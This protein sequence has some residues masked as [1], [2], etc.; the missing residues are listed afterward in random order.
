MHYEAK[1]EKRPQGRKAYEKM[2]RAPKGGKGWGAKRSR[3]SGLR[4]KAD[5]RDFS[6]G[7]LPRVRFTWST[8]QWASLWPS[9]VIKTGVSLA[10][11]SAL[12]CHPSQPPGRHPLATSYP[13][14]P[15]ARPFVCS[16]RGSSRFVPVTASFTRSLSSSFSFALS[17]AD[18]PCRA[19][20]APTTHFFGLD[21]LFFWFTS[22]CFHASFYR[23]ILFLLT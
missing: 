22:N 5:F 12:F 21:F 11:Q 10:T 13:L 2:E 14:F 15:S 18:G 16:V 9:S 7:L 8:M 17:A 4:A 1:K 6:P 20:L 3:V 23:L 19:S